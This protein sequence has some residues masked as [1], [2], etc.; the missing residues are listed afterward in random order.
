MLATPAQGSDLAA[1]ASWISGNPQFR[2]MAPSDFNA[3]LQSLD[4]DFNALLRRR[5]ATAPF[6]KVFC[7]YETL[8]TGPVKVVPRSRSQLGCDAT[9]NAF[10]R[11]HVTIAKPTGR[12]DEIHVY[13]RARILESISPSAV[14]QTVSIEWIQE[15]ACS[16]AAC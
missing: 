13:L 15:G 12:D 4:N 10:D 5:G 8:A 6:P 7:A 14:K 16:I 9:P 3:Y 2:D 11:T 1:L